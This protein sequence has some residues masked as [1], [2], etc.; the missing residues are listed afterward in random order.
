MEQSS[1]LSK[2]SHVICYYAPAI[3]M[4]LF[5]WFLGLSDDRRPFTEAKTVILA[6]VAKAIFND[7]TPVS[8]LEEQQKS[9][10]EIPVGSSVWVYNETFSPLTDHD[11]SDTLLTAV[12]TLTNHKVNISKPIAVPVKGE[13]V[14]HRNKPDSQDKVDDRLMSDEEIHN[15]LMQ[16]TKSSAVLLYLHGG[17]F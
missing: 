16:D 3:V 7:P 17:Q 2:L 12:T 1:F 4:P 8:M 10:R 11:L 14:G 9:R 5:T 15:N 13:W 6:T